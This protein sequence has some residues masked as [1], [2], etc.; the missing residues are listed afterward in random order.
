MFFLKQSF[1]D[2]QLQTSDFVWI[3]IIVNN[4]GVWGVFKQPC[5]PQNIQTTSLYNENG[6]G[7]RLNSLCIIVT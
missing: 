4:C 2:L 5:W 7:I 3:L 6:P 1:L